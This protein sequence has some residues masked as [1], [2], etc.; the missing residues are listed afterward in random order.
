MVYSLWID[1]L[2]VD[3]CLDDL[4]HEEIVS[5][6]HPG[7]D[8]PAFEIG[9]AFGDQRWRDLL[10]RKRRQSEGRELVGVAARAVADLYGFFG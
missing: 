9:E 1:L 5:V 8:D 10:G 6:H 7:I 4:Q 2:R 3:P